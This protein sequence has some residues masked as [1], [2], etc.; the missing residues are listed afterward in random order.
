MTIQRR[1]GGWAGLGLS[2]SALVIVSGCAPLE[3]EDRADAPLPSPP[4]YVAPPMAPPPPPAPSRPAI[5]GLTAS[6]REDSVDE[7]VVSAS[8]IP[9]ASASPVPPGPGRPMPQSGILTAGDYDDLLNPALYSA[10][11]GRQLQDQ[12]NSR[13]PYV[14]TA[15][16]VTIRVTDV[17]DR[18]MPFVEVRATRADG[19]T[20]SLRTVADG[21]VTLFPALD[22]LGETSRITVGSGRNAVTRTLTPGQDRVLEVRLAGTAQ[23]VQAFDLL[24]V[25][26]ATGSMS[27]E[28]NYL[29]SELT[30]IMAAVAE[31]HP[32]VDIRIGLIVY[33]DVGDDYVVRQFGFTGNVGAI[34]TVLAR[35]D[36]GGG[37]DYPE[38]VDQAMATALDFPWREDAVKALMLVADAPPHDDRIGQTWATTLEAR[39]ERIQIVPLAASGV[40][41]KAEFVMR[42]MAAATQSRYLFL[43]DDSGVGLPHD[44]PEV[45]CYAVTRL[46]GLVRRVL[47]SLISGRRIEPTEAEVIRRVGPYDRGVCN[48]PG[49][50]A[51]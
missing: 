40:A 33:R 28:M 35:Q 16:A 6:S 12:A 36:A 7:I 3:G 4:P 14:D 8:R 10:Y 45:K 17:R 1:T 32:G 15:R 27:D 44:T 46:D 26:D 47:D 19:T 20:I 51:G 13:L 43:T 25:I 48:V 29:K 18:P 38:A 30:S 50:K 23:A 22:G 39:R 24:L 34:Q 42:A 9:P 31:R 11:V 21:A 5:V 41:D 37:G 2:L 49:P